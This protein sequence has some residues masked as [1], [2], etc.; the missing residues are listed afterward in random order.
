MMIALAHLGYPAYFSN[1]LGVAKL[2]GVCVLL[3]PGLGRFKEWAYTGF[4]ITILSAAYSHWC[5]GDGLMALEPLVTF[6]ALVISYRTRATGQT[7]THYQPGGESQ[8]TSFASA[9]R[10]RL[11]QPGGA[12][13]GVNT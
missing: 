5:S 11:P 8:A 2:A 4:A 7:P 13:G 1:L 10:E 12:T 6:A 3:A 9:Q